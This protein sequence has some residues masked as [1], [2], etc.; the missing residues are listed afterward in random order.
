[1]F[2]RGCPTAYM[3][4]TR[5]LGTSFGLGRVVG[6]YYSILTLGPQQ[7]RRQKT[8]YVNIPLH[9]SKFQECAYFPSLENLQAE[10]F[11]QESFG[12]CLFALWGGDPGWPT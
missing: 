7:K 3:C 9:L 1:M 11:L 8:P 10:Q 4:P 12:S 5:M 2:F 6:T